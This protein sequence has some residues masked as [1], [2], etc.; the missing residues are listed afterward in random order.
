QTSIQNGLSFGIPEFLERPA[1][2]NERRLQFADTMTY[3]SGN[4]TFKFGGDVNLV[5]DVINN[6]RFSGGEFNYTGNG[7]LPL[8]DFA[9]DYINFTT[10]GTIRAL[11]ATTPTTNPLGRCVSS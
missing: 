3:T 1:F 6:L 5:Q 9:V 8:S 11:S 10:N 4:H 7:V 2:P